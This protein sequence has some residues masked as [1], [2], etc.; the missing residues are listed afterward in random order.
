MA[1]GGHGVISYKLEKDTKSV[2]V[3]AVRGETF[4]LPTNFKSVI[5]HRGTKYGKTP[6]A[7]LAPCSG[8]KSHTYTVLI[9]AV[10]KN[11]LELDTAKLTLGKY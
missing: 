1:D 5:A 3:P 10:D 8:G 11:S 7:Y 9:Q 6:G 2:I 4:N